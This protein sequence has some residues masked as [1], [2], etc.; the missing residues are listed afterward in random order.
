MVIDNWYCQCTAICHQSVSVRV[1]LLFVLFTR[2]TIQLFLI[3]L[4]VPEEDWMH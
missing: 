1:E 2:M 4:D 3:H